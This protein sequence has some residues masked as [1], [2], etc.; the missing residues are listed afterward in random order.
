MMIKLWIL[1]SGTELILSIYWAAESAGFLSLQ[2]NTG[3]RTLCL[4]Y[5]LSTVFMYIELI[6]NDLAVNAI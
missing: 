6:R 1:F 3:I 2:K 4:A 5:R